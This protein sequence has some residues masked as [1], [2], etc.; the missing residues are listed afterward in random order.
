MS[1]GIKRDWISFM[2]HVANPDEPLLWEQE[3]AGREYALTE[4]LKWDVEKAG[5]QDTGEGTG[6]K[7]AAESA[8]SLTA[9]ISK[10]TERRLK[11]LKWVYRLDEE[12]TLEK[13]IGNEVTRLFKE[14]AINRWEM[15]AVEFPE[16]LPLR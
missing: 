14:G 9:N 1:R 15:D 5:R 13:A 12:E 2:H 11:L 7:E 10:L 6:G 8:V 4:R 16:R 3:S